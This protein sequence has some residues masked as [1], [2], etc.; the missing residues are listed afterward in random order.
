MRAH[1]VL[2]C[3]S[4]EIPMKSG[5]LSMDDNYFDYFGEKGRMH[6]INLLVPL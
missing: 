1:N 3:I 6:L 2:D 4:H 5:S